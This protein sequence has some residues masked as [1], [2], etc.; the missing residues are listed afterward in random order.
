MEYNNY[1]TDSGDNYTNSDNQQLEQ[2]NTDIHVNTY[3]SRK[4]D[5]YPL[6][7]QCTYAHEALKQFV[8]NTTIP[9]YELGDQDKLFEF[10]IH[11]NHDTVPLETSPPFFEALYRK[12]L[13]WMTELVLQQCNDFIPIPVST[14]YSIF[15]PFVYN[16]SSKQYLYQFYDDMLSFDSLRNE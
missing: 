7:L 3:C 6:Y 14:F 16:K 1:E 9:L 13:I 12:Y 15:V 10:I 4:E 11:I 8:D 5:P 2:S